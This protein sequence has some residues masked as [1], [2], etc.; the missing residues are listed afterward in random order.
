VDYAGDIAPTILEIETGQVDSGADLKWISQFPNE[1]EMLISPLSN[2]EVVSMCLEYCREDQVNGPQVNVFKCRLNLNMNSKTLESILEARK[3]SVID[4][5]RS[6]WNEAR[7]IVQT[8]PL[9]SG[10]LD[11]NFS[12]DYLKKRMLIGF[13]IAITFTR[14]LRFCFTTGDKSSTRPQTA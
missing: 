8:P 9:E 3:T 1:M 2:F 13:M 6:L 11:Q 5:G 14:A 10:I 12:A 4:L 7:Q